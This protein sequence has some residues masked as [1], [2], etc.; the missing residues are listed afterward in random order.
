M[1]EKSCTKPAAVVVPGTVVEVEEGGA[2]VLVMGAGKR[3]E[4]GRVEG[5]GAEVDVTV[6]GRSGGVEMGVGKKEAPVIEEMEEDDVE[7]DIL[8]AEDTGFPRREG[9]IMLGASS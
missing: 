1:A 4:V 5:G 3:V 2:P 7:L 8:A 6:L 9:G